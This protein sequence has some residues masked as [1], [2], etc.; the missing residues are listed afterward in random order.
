M[1]ITIL[2][3]IL[4][5]FGILKGQNQPPTYKP[6]FKLIVSAGILNGQTGV[7]PS[8]QAIPGFQYKNSFAGIGTGIDYYNL[9]SVPVFADIRQEFGKKAKKFLLYSDGGYCFDWI[10]MDRDR[11]FSQE[12]YS[13]GLYYDAGLGYKVAFGNAGALML[14]TG[15]SGKRLKKEVRTTPICSGI[16]PCPQETETFNYSFSTIVFRVGWQF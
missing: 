11:T 9:R 14:T 6:E 3:L 4:F 1:R 12:D 5:S 10:I 7:N 8:V 15:Y 16:G 13:G 2:L